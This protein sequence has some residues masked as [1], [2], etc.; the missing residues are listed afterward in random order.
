MASAWEQVD[1]VRQLNEELRQAQLARELA[2]RLAAR[3][4]MVPNA[5]AVL[6][7]TAPLHA[8]LMA[9]PATIRSVLQQSAIPRGVFEGTFRRVAR[10]LGPLGRR[11]GLAAVASQLIERLN[12]GTLSAAPAPAVP[13]GM[14]TP[15]KLGGGLAPGET[16]ASAARRARLAFW[17]MVAAILLLLVAII[18]ALAGAAAIAGVV[19]A[20]AAAT[21]F[22]AWRLR[23]QAQATAIAVGLRTGTLTGGD[24][25]AAP[26]PVSFVPQA[27]PAGGPPATL[28]ATSPATPA[29]P[30]AATAF[31]E[32]M[33]RLFDRMAPPTEPLSVAKPVSLQGLRTTLVTKLDPVVT[34]AAAY[35]QRFTLVPGVIWQPDDPIE[36]IHAAPEFPQPMYDELK[37]LSADW[38][39]PGFSQIP[40]NTV[41]LL[42]TNQ[43]MIESFMVGLNH[44]MTRELLWRE[45]PLEQRATYFRQFWDTR[46]AVPPPGGVLDPDKLKDI[47][48]VHTWPKPSVLGAH[49]P[50]PPPPG[51]GD[52]LVFFIRGDLL[53]RYP[54]TVVYA[55]RA[56]WLANGLRDIDDPAPGASAEEISQKQ[57]WP[58]FTGM[59]DPDANF[60]GFA[61]TKEQVRGARDAS[62]DPGWFFILQ[63]HSHEPRFG[64]YASEAETVGL[65]VVGSTWDNLSWGSLTADAAALDSLLTIDLD[66]DLPDTTQ[67]TS[68]GTR[69]WHANRGRGQTG[70]RASDL[71]FITFRRPMRVGIHGEDMVP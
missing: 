58:L 39:L 50:R 66:A 26:L 41:T 23:Q 40:V 63:E 28:P 68:P 4:V 34:F 64:L 49:C 14:A 6:A 15:T 19:V 65:P 59:L 13:S 36:P 3:H 32:S 16:A 10:P 46:G 38:I 53:R 31:R 30:V 24:I 55:A 48:P 25:R 12:A 9:S 61:L 2:R 17:L 51:G 1:R 67:V 57:S 70:S 62:G 47:T 44:E 11:L 20:V 33:A 22:A 69:A 37:K 27:A 8:R 45:Y 21:G 7:I 29:N 43:K 60:F 35:K 5:E 18:L 42:Q 54:N 52:Y 71:A 56:K